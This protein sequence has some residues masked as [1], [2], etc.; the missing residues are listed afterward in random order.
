MTRQ[1][2]GQ[3]TRGTG[4]IGQ[5]RQQARPVELAVDRLRAY[6]ATESG[7]VRAVDDVS[8]EV[9]PGDYLGIVGES[10]CGKTTLVKAIF[11]LLP[12]DA[13][14][15]GEVRLDGRN[16]LAMTPIELRRTRWT[17]MSLITQSAMNSL[18]PV[19][20]VGDQIVEA[21]RA[22]GEV[23]HDEAW[24][25]AVEMFDLVG[26]VP[27]RLENYPHQF[28]GGMR[29][30]AIIAL[31]LVLQPGLI[32]A[33][34]P[35]TALDVITQDQIL[36]RIRRIHE[37]VSASM[38]FV[39]HDISVIAE[40]CDAMVVMYAGKIVECGPTVGVLREPC[41]PYTMGLRNAF[42]NIKG[43]I[44]RL[45]AIPGSPPSLIDPPRGCRFAERCPFATDRCRD[46]EPP[47]QSVGTGHS[48][49]CHYADQAA[50]LRERA[51]EKSTWDEVAVRIG[52]A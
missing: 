48:A 9:R 18:D 7:Y 11:R 21:I 49:A 23:S 42:P 41:H 24:Q 38:I 31:S 47:L 6:Y 5:L 25:R 14:V 52:L 46:G 28:S 10:G 51:K 44:G 34:E 17:R 16:V 36:G 8:F 2:A 26:L 12:D 33:D 29:Q 35:T 27:E 39:T 22:H 32:I 15:E 43:G 45:I 30:R 20:R 50:G 19:Y 40:T 13:F 37:A 1:A 3:A 4:L